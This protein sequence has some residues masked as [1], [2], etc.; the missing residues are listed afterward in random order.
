MA[1]RVE[2][3]DLKKNDYFTIS[4][5][6]EADGI[7][8]STPGDDPRIKEAN[9]CITKESILTFLENLRSNVS[10]SDF[11]ARYII[12]H[13]NSKHK[14]HVGDGKDWHTHE[15]ALDKT[16]EFVQMLIKKEKK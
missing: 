8:F 11:K 2:R 15:C 4:L 12:W 14:D 1:A 9:R 3:D 5:M 13:S 6:R 7:M 10:E 16:I